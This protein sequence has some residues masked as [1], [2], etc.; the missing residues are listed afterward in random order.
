MIEK[1]RFS[2]SK[3]WL[4]VIVGTALVLVIKLGLITKTAW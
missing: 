1:G 3:D 4:A 2:I